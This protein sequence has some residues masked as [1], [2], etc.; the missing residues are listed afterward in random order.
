MEE[1]ARGGAGEGEIAVKFILRYTPRPLNLVWGAV[2]IGIAP[3]SRSGMEGT[4][5]SGGC[6]GNE[7]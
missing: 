7:P 3:V 5:K 6:Y 1:L 4:A 2:W